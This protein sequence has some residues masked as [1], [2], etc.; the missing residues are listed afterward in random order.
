M[1]SINVNGAGLE[2]E[3]RGAGEPVLLI[4]NYAVSSRELARDRRVRE[5]GVNFEASVDDG[6]QTS[7][8]CGRYTER[9][10]VIGTVDVSLTPIVAGGRHAVYCRGPAA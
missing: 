7:W 2:Y 1:D 9:E 10:D 8:T 5:A 3:V 6:G 4:D